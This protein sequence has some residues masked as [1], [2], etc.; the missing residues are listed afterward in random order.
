[1]TVYSEQGNLPLLR[2]RGT[3]LVHE[4]RSIRHINAVVEDG[5]AQ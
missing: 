1:M 4:R 2:K 5:V 3:K